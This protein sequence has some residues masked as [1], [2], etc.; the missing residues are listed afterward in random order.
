MVIKTRS[1]PRLYKALPRV[2]ISAPGRLTAQ[3]LRDARPMPNITTGLLKTG[4]KKSAKL[5][6]PLRS[7]FILRSLE[8]VSRKREFFNGWLET[9]GQF[10]KVMVRL[11]SP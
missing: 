9:S 2:T 11:R 7:G 3:M 5:I 8:R 4:M 1:L 10:R 6:G